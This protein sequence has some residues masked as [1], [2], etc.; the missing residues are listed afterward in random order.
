MNTMSETIP[1]SFD[2]V[3]AMLNSLSRSDRRRLTDMM[4]AQLERE[5]AEAKSSIEESILTD[6]S[7]REESDFRLTLALS[8]FHKDWGGEKEPLEI[9]NEL[10]QGADK[11][12]DVETW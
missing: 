12:R 8:H 2:A 10:R 3:L 7:W 4:R 5:E 1:I 9:A 6:S 11:V